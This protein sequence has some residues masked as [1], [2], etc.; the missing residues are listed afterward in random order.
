MRD[1]ILIIDHPELGLPESMTWRYFV[2]QLSLTQW[3][4]HVAVLGIRLICSVMPIGAA[5]NDA[6]CFAR[7]VAC[8]HTIDRTSRS[9]LSRSHV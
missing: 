3:I 1:G 7:S 6:C 2:S 5:T 9:H 4:T 8:I